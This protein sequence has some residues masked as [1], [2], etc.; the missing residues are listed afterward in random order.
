MPKLSAA[1]LVVAVVV[2]ATSFVAGSKSSGQAGTGVGFGITAA[3][4]PLGWRFPIYVPAASMIS[5]AHGLGFYSAAP[6]THGV[7]LENIATDGSPQSGIHVSVFVNGV[8]VR[9]LGSLAF[10]GGNPVGNSPILIR[11]GDSFAVIRE[12]VFNSAVG[13]SFDAAIIP[14]SQLPAIP[15]M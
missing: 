4:I 3:E 7:L 10:G 13:I 1:F 8:K 15:P 12:P 5:A 2:F 11:P 9:S 6:A 14:A